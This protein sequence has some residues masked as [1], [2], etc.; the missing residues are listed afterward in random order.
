MVDRYPESEHPY[1]RQL[2]GWAQEL[3]PELILKYDENFPGRNVVVLGS[4][5]GWN[6]VIKPIRDCLRTAGFGV[7]APQGEEI[8]RYAAGFEILDNDVAKIDTMEQRLQRRMSAKEVAVFLEALFMQAIDLSDL[9]YL[10]GLP[11][12][13]IDDG[14]YMGLQVAC[15][16]GHAMACNIPIFGTEISPTLDDR[17]GYDGRA[18]HFAAHVAM[19]EVVTPEELGLRYATIAV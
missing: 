17:D 5:K 3:A 12:E 19:I 14:G 2:Q 15:E 1:Y 7:L 4:F 8:V 10:A 11:R 6:A 9:V 16:L 18:S 13:D